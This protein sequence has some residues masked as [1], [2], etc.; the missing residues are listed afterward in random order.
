MTARSTTAGTYTTQLSSGRT[1]TTT[2]PSV[3]API[4][5]G[6][7]RLDVEDR[8]PGAT[9]ARTEL[10]RRTL[11]LDAL[12]PWSRIPEP[13]D[14]AG[15]GRYR[16]TIDLPSDWTSCHGAHLDL[17]QVCDTAR[18]TVNGIGAPP[19]DRLR[20]VVDVGPLL[21]RGANVIEVEVAT[22]LV[23]R[24]RV[25]RPTV[26]GAVARQDH[27]LMGPVRLLPYGQAVIG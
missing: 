21:R 12:L 2:V 8:R 3:P 20:P 5:P 19:V 14:S 1:V 26:F 23:N 27:G 15:I 11:T 17:G 24:L 13:A 4:T 10:V 22:P 7:W 16:T 18:V 9:P 25:A 6:R